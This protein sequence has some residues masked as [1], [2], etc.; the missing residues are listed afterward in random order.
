MGSGQTLWYYARRFLAGLATIKTG[1]I[2]GSASAAQL[3]DI[4]ANLAKLKAQA[5]N[6]GNVYLGTSSSVTIADGTTDTTTGFELAGGDE[7]PWLPL[8]NLNELYLICDNA[9]DDLTYVIL[10]W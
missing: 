2:E 5:G 4:S 6:S 7:T 9:G 10:E 8:E 3:P 1:E